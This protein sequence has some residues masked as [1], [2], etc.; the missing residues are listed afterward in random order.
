MKYL[1]DTSILIEAER[2]NFDLGN[3]ASAAEEVWICDATVAEYLAGQPIKDANK[4]KRWREFWQSLQ[5]PS[6]P[7]TRFVCEQAGALL[8]LGRKKGATIPLGDG[9]HA[10][11]AAMEGLEV[12]CKDIEHFSAMGVKATNPLLTSPPQAS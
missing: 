10:A 1:I 12:L 3:W 9:F 8:F 7:L 2:Q 11:V 4:A 5:I 6:K